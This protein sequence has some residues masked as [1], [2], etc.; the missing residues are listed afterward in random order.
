MCFFLSFFLSKNNMEGCLS[1][2]LKESGGL[3]PSDKRREGGSVVDKRRTA[4]PFVKLG[5]EHVL[6][7][8]DSGTEGLF[9]S[10][11]R[12]DVVSFFW[13]RK[14]RCPFFDWSKERKLFLCVSREEKWW[15]LLSFRRQEGEVFLLFHPK[16]KEKVPLLSRCE[17]WVHLLL[18]T[19][20]CKRDLFSRREGHVF[21]FLES[22]KQ[23]KGRCLYFC[24]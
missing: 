2:F 9:L 17:G 13:T 4:F 7:V 15:S 1:E 20:L 6:C 14:G 3:F 8:W 12:R 23:Q 22:R 11:K 21:L 5:R 16:R 24:E 19:F 10:N 18:R